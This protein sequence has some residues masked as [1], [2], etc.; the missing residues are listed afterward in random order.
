MEQSR[1]LAPSAPLPDAHCRLHA[2]EGAGHEPQ[3]LGVVST[4]A[5]LALATGAA[6]VVGAAANTVA[7]SLGGVGA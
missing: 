3:V 7:Q 6:V 2:G 4:V 5:T 1:V